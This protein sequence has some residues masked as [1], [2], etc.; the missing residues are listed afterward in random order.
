[1]TY[2]DPGICELQVM[3][4]RPDAIDG[5]FLLF[6]TLSDIAST[7]SGLALRVSAH[8]YRSVWLPDFLYIFSL[9]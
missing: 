7:P 6:P 8:D 4:A 5:A 1:M 9:F 2:L 3:K